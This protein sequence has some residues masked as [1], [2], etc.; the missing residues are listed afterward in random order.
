MLSE[1]VSFREREYPKG[2]GLFSKNKKMKKDIQ[3]IGSTIIHEWSRVNFEAVDII[4]PNWKPWV[5]EL[6]CRKWNPNVVSALI[7]NTTNNTYI[8]IEQFRV[9]AKTKVLELVAW[10]TWDKEI[11]MTLEEYL[12]DEVREEVWY[13]VDK[14][15][16]LMT[17]PKSPWITNEIWNI[18]YVQ[19][20]WESLG[21]ALED[22]ERIDML[23]VPKDQID[24]FLDEYEKSWNMVSWEIGNALY[25]LSRMQK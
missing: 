1:C 14:V 4:K 24:D 9:W 6:A 25:K 22:S 3:I 19:V 21:Q 13:V 15:K 7:E 18:Y 2:E 17:Y 11:D 23:E 12:A 16:K 5:R 10:I 20:S 8:L